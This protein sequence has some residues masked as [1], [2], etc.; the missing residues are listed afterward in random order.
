[1]PSLFKRKILFTVFLFIGVLFFAG[2]VR[3][4]DLEAVECNGGERKDGKD[5]YIFL[6]TTSGET[7]ESPE[8]DSAADPLDGT[9]T[10]IC[11][12]V[13]KGSG[14]VTYQDLISNSDF[15]SQLLSMPGGNIYSLDELKVLVEYYNNCNATLGLFSDIWQIDV[16]KSNNNS[17]INEARFLLQRGEQ[18]SCALFSSDRMQ[19]L[20]YNFLGSSIKGLYFYYMQPFTNYND[21]KTIKVQSAQYC[22]EKTEMQCKNE[23]NVPC[24]WYEKQTPSARC[25]SR[26]DT[27][28]CEK[29]SED[30][31]GT[32]TGSKACKWNTEQKQC[33]TILESSISGTHQTPEGY[34]SGKG[35][36]LMPP[37]AFDG[38][39]KNVN[40]LVQ[41]LVN[42]GKFAIGGVG[43]I[44][45]VMFFYGGLKV[46]FSF[47][48][49]EKVKEGWKVLGAAI[50]GLVIMFS[51]YLL[52]NFILD[53]LGVVPE[54][55]AF[56]G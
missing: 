28:L 16:E 3:A 20:R 5:F 24:F 49:A 13:D 7:T 40:D 50:I 31:C 53:A 26:T 35:S 11:V 47:G 45:F 21:L 6:I 1:M 23:Y 52:I 14:Y 41:L 2:Q 27:S 46:I 34:Y 42:Y 12:E 32:D 18:H 43:F 51:A 33:Q 4:Y 38:S 37:C 54:F 8:D 22:N 44:A 55:R 19:R 56:G 25:E 10:P 15:K 29:L 17:N 48:N 39:C 36:G 30:W 9:A